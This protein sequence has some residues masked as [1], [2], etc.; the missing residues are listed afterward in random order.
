MKLAFADTYRYVSE[1][2]SMDGEPRCKC[3]MPPTSH[4]VPNS[5]T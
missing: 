3:S 2:S 1:P 4:R 5:S